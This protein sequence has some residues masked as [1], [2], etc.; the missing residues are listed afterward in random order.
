MEVQQGSGLLESASAIL[1]QGPISLQVIRIPIA[2]AAATVGPTRVG[3]LHLS[4]RALSER[5]KFTVRGYEFT[6]F[7][8]IATKPSPSTCW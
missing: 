3:P 7:S 6:S 5:H 2:T 4:F 8:R 1:I